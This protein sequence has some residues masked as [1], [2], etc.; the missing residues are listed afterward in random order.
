MNGCV[1]TACDLW[2]T[3][4]NSNNN[5][6]NFRTFVYKQVRAPWLKHFIYCGEQ[7]LDYII[8]GQVLYFLIMSHFV[9]QL[10]LINSFN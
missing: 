4:D 9:Y 3:A 10:L 5:K 2:A 8:P 6:N 7:A 1:T